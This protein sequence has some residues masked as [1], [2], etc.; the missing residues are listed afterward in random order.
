MNND[1]AEKVIRL[2]EVGTSE[3]RWSKHPIARDSATVFLERPE[4]PAVQ[5]TTKPGGGSSNRTNH[6]VTSIK[7]RSFESLI[8][9]RINKPNFFHWI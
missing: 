1:E 6:V 8:S 9:V 7:R 5:L 3:W 4:N 2:V